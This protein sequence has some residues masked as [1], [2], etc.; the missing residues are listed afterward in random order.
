MQANM[1]EIPNIFKYFAPFKAY[2]GILSIPHSGETIPAEF[3]PYLTPDLRAIAEDVDYK[4]DELV[5]ISAL[6][7]AGVAVI[8]AN[9]HRVCVDLN[10]APNICVLNWKENSQGVPLVLK[11]PDNKTSELFHLKYYAPYF[12]MLKSMIQEL[13]KHQS[14][15]I[16]IIDLHSM[17]SR[18]TDYHLKINPNQMV[19]RPDFCVSDISGLSCEKDFINY[20]C[21]QLHHI[22]H[23]VTQNDPYFG[24]HVTRH[25]HATFNRKNNIQIEI[26]RALYMD[27][28]HRNLIPSKSHLLKSQLTEKLINIF[29]HFAA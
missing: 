11:T 20:T 12:E 22:S 21:E 9:I 6:R 23:L 2:I 18:A 15:N 7:E 5:D 10:R 16:S 27:E 25:I 26:N 3:L 13:H 28:I 17:P 24:G 29:K 8:V 1:T 4:V 14:G 19:N